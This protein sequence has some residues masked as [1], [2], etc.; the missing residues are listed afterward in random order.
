MSQK[1]SNNWNDVGFCVSL[2]EKIENKIRAKE[3]EHKLT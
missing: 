2:V 1:S 3:V